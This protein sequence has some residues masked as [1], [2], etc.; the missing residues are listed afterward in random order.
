M[1][2]QAFANNGNIFCFPACMYFIADMAPAAL[3]AELVYVMRRA[4][5]RPLIRLDLPAAYI[6]YLRLRQA[7]LLLGAGRML[8][9]GKMILAESFVA[10]RTM[11]QCL[12]IAFVAAPRGCY[13]A[14]AGFLPRRLSCFLIFHGMLLL[15]P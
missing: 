7:H 2:A 6:T 12:L 3:A 9:L 15:D 4:R 11:P 13:A 8:L 14:A 5:Q 1:A 10:V